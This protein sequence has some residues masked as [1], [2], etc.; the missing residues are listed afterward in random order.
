MFAPKDKRTRKNL[1]AFFITVFKLP[2]KEQMQSNS[3]HLFRKFLIFLMT[4]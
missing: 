2:L 3:L 1:E 4:S